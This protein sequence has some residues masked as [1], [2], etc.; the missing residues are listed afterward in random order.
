ME[1]YE[2]Y[3]IAELIADYVEGNITP[4]KQQE[5]DH[6]ANLSENNRKLLDE[7]SRYEFIGRKQI[8]ENL[9]DKEKAY[10]QFVRQK[11]KHI[12]GRN[13]RRISS[14]SAAALFV[15]LLGVATAL[16]VR[17]P[18]VPEAPVVSL[19]TAGESRALLTLADGREMAL[20]REMADT[21]LQ[22]D[23]A[24][25][26]I[27]G[28]GLAYRENEG[29]DKLIY[30]QLEVPRKGEFFLTLSDGTKVWLNSDSRLRYPVCFNTAERRV[31]LEGE[32]YFEV[33]EN[34]DKPFVVEFKNAAVRV[35]GTVFNARAYSG[36]NIYTTLEKGRVEL[37]ANNKKIELA[38]DEQG[39]VDVRSGS[40]IKRRVDVRL[41]TSWKDG[42]FVFENQTLEEMMETLERW[43]DISV[44][45]SSQSVR[46]VTFSGNLK[47]YDSFDKIIELLE[48]TGLARFETKGNVVY[49]SN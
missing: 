36:D 26:N 12:R 30:N 41:Y 13:L 7:F 24:I 32:A 29:A 11:Q 4:G 42:R 9:C 16:F 31:Y 15:I 6:W 3:R 48:M 22:N 37:V 18:Q 27:S 33:K 23:G 34:T 44:F 17:P 8:A 25:L 45:F 1:I 43:Y 19:I 2:A 28:E 38:P 21:L 35:L 49:I 10:K 5:L 14:W 47:R 39:V 40:I 46:K 20:Y